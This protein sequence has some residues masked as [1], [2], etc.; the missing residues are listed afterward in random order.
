MTDRP[1]K[2]RRALPQPPEGT[3]VEGEGNPGQT[4]RSSSPS[5]GA[6]RI[7]QLYDAFISYSHAVDG[8]LA[9]ALQKGL[10]RFAKPWWR[11]RALRVF[12]DQTSLATSPELWPS[13]ERALSRSRFFLYLASP[14][15]AQSFWVRRELDYWFTH[16][17]SDK[18]L[19]VL[20]EGEL[21]WNRDA[22]EFDWEATDAFPREV[23]HNFDGEPLW[24][25]LRDAGNADDLSLN[26]LSFRSGV[27]NLVSALSGRPKDELIGEDVRRHRQT[28]RVAWSAAI[29]LALLTLTSV[30]AALLALD[31][32]RTAEARRR[33]AESRQLASQ[34]VAATSKGRLDLGM[35][36]G[37]EALQTVQELEQRHPDDDVDARAALFQAV[38]A[39]PQLQ[40]YVH[41]ARNLSQVVFS[42]DGRLGLGFYRH[43]AV[44][45]VDA[46]AGTLPTTLEP[47]DAYAPGA[48]SARSAMIVDR[49]ARIA[50]LQ[51]RLLGKEIPPPGAAVPGC[52]SGTRAVR[53]RKW[54]ATVRRQATP[55]QLRSAP[56]GTPSLRLRPQ[57]G[58]ACWNLRPVKS[59]A[60]RWP[61]AVACKTWHSQLME[62]NC[63]LRRIVRYLSGIC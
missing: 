29:G 63:W 21:R 9:P 45:Q 25:D 46:A 62:A 51:G 34:S 28:R 30:V 35:L 1:W 52:S 59:W 53:S 6:G 50:D 57:T 39:R 16:R 47:V 22:G 20:T 49:K 2:D 17:S 37:V 33:L 55:W 36:L 4:D 14:Q 27:A 19:I 18:L 3:R 26:N 31:A 42:P 15:A 12:R 41:N 38:H 23:H 56:M 58:C 40:R 10:H 11:L 54:C 5:S 61:L 32:Q 8:R 44:V 13:I 48:P 43:V 60:S 24:L 7:A